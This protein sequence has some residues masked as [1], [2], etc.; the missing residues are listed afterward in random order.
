MPEK[1]RWQK[2][3]ALAKVKDPKSQKAALKE[4]KKLTEEER[5]VFIVVY[6]HECEAADARRALPG[7]GD[8]AFDDALLSAIKKLDQ[9]AALPEPGS[10]A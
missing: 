3:A 5:R 7:M 2:V 9:G 6:V 8:E 1:K 4:L 10:S